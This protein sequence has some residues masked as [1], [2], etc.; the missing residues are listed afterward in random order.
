MNSDGH[1]RHR[2]EIGG[3]VLSVVEEG[4]GPAIL[5]GHGYL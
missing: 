3:G 5:L 4:Q 1:R 2:L